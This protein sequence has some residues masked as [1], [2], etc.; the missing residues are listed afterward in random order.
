[1]QMDAEERQ[2]TAFGP[3]PPP[4]DVANHA[5]R[6]RG[7]VRSGSKGN[8]VVEETAI[9]CGYSSASNPMMTCYSGLDTAEMTRGHCGS[10]G[11]LKLGIDKV[12]A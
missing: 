10:V 7:S 8:P 6:I 4:T 1:M 5:L 3:Y 11:Y 12:S 9:C 2:D